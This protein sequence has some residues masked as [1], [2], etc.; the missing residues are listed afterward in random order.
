MKKIFI[1]FTITTAS[2]FSEPLTIPIQEVLIYS[3]RAQ[4]T[5]R[6]EINI[7]PGET[8]FKI[9]SLPVNLMDSTLRASFPESNQLNISS[10]NSFVELTTNF[11]DSSI[12][13][14]KEKIDS[15]EKERK[16][17]EGRL[18]S[19]QKEKSLNSDFE[20]LTIGSVS[21]NAAYTKSEQ[22]VLGWK[23]SFESLKNK[24]L[25]L[26]NYSHETQ[27]ELDKVTSE[28]SILDQKLNKIISRSGK[29]I[30]TT[31]VKVINSSN[32]T[33][34]YPL[35][36]SYLV[37]GAL[38]N[39]VYNITLSENG[40]IEVEYI[41]EIQ[42]E[43]GENWKNVKLSLSTAEPRKSQVRPKV[44]GTLLHNI[45]T[46]T[47]KDNFFL[48]KK[49][50]ARGATT[51]AA[52]VAETEPTNIEGSVDKTAGSF[53]FH[54]S[55]KIEI[56][57]DKEFHRVAISKFQA[58][59]KPELLTIPKLKKTVFLTGRIQ[60][61]ISFPL[62][63]GKVNLYRESGYV[64]ESSISYI[65]V[66]SEFTI[67]FG[68]ENN[69]RVAYRVDTKN[70]NSGIVSNKKVFEKN[71]YISIENFDKSEKKINVMDQIP[72]SDIEEA[73]IEIDQENS[74]S[75]YKEKV[76][77]SGI[78]EWSVTI[79]PNVKKELNLKY[80]V[81]VPATSSLNF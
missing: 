5:R 43:S 63:A 16:F 30:R 28:L 60:N 52:P 12:Q 14:L 19:I 41:A 9:S 34:N 29:S 79:S 45:E 1:I 26:E 66:G 13:E 69:V 38:W 70:Y 54:S 57:S 64:G 23:N 31:E 46:Q 80:K 22:E 17:L 77:N 68:I 15:K 24:F 50:S 62:L 37:S 48:Y 11:N 65:P 10:V 81:K 74:T 36:V 7:P 42:Q 4:I 21:Y 27:K 47:K 51:M 6:L 35:Q 71:L 18:F 78:Y 49:E 58:N 3:D 53:I 59:S 33:I 61:K 56:P 2:L 75:G 25:K 32:K 40:Q 20:K 73:E 76:K 72:V 67:S 55:E 44:F 8:I 39:P